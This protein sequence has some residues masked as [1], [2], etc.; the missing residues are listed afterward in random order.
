MEK[1][2]KAPS[3]CHQ[4]ASARNIPYVKMLVTTTK[5][6]SV[7]NLDL[8]SH[9]L[10]YYVSC[11]GDFLVLEQDSQGKN[12]TQRLQ[13]FNKKG[14]YQKTLL[15]RGRDDVTSMTGMA[16]DNTSNVVVTLKDGQGIGRVNAYNM[17]GELVLAAKISV[18]NPKFPPFFT[19]VAVDKEGR[20]VVVEFHEMAVHIY[21]QNG[22]FVLKIG[23][24]GRTAQPGV[25]ENIS[26]L[27]I[28]QNNEIY[29]CDPLRSVQVCCSIYLTTRFHFAMRVYCNRSRTKS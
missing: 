24:G 13:L 26:C 15:Q 2:F 29:V 20:I 25:F 16:L 10:F 27:S 17:K 9:I 12:T 3:L 1:S 8:S 28:S 23:Q 5:R 11:L 14:R 18:P 19:S 7:Y 21:G 4:Q 6:Y 22:E